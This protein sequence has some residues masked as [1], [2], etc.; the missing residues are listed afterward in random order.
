MKPLRPS[1]Q[2][3]S[4]SF[5]FGT[6]TSLALALLV[7]SPSASAV[8]LP[9]SGVVCDLPQRICF[10][11]RGP[12]LPLT[13]QF[14]GPQAANQL[15]GQ[16]SGRP[17]EREFQLSQGQ[18]CDLQLRLCWDDGW[19][20]G[21]VNTLLSRHLFGSAPGNAPATGAGITKPP[22]PAFGEIGDRRCQL[23]RRQET[24]VKGFC[25]LYRQIE[26]LG[27]Y[28]V[29]RLEKGQLYRFQRRGSILVLS[30]AT[31]TWPVQ[32]KEKSD[33]VQF[34]WADLQLEVSRPSSSRYGSGAGFAV[35]GGAT[36]RS[37]GEMSSD[38]MDTLFP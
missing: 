31:G 7:A 4:I 26:G 11:S 17:P 10:D 24:V 34:R 18:L 20:R 21:R 22:G 35:S 19:R 16:L 14:Y 37:T 13:R 2:A 25:R 15:R 1:G 8:D 33:T 32:L 3:R 6:G 23:Q 38:L 30:D 36:P 9:R 27:R 29:V 28:Y 12:S 5:C